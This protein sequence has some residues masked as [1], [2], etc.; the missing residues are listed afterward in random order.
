ML[1]YLTLVSLI[2]NLFKKIFNI[3]LKTNS[4]LVMKTFIFMIKPKKNPLLKS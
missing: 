3:L 4:I 1:L 2:K